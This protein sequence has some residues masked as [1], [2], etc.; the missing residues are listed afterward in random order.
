MSNNGMFQLIGSGISAAGSLFG[1]GIDSRAQERMN[2]Q[3]INLQKEFAQNSI[4][5]K[6]NDAKKAG[7]HPLYA[8]GANTASFTPSS[9]ISNFGSSIAQAGAHLGQGL[10]SINFEQAKNA[11]LQ[12]ELLQAQIESQKLQNSSFARTM[13]QQSNQQ[14][15][16]NEALVLNAV[17]PK[18]NTKTLKDPTN[19]YLGKDK[20]QL[21]DDLTSD[22]T[23]LGVLSQARQL[24]KQAPWITNNKKLDFLDSLLNLSPQYVDEK[25][26][27]M[28]DRFF[29]KYNPI[30]WLLNFEDRRREKILQNRKR[31]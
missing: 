28:I 21:I 18:V 3:N 13:G 24:E 15:K 4:Q 19:I 11:R 30:H 23:T 1:G 9:Q 10:S 12:N 7:I 5:W 17:S 27:T 14:N 6:V 26:A 20:S 22:K 2:A 29:Y 25:D 8:I 31:K 16:I